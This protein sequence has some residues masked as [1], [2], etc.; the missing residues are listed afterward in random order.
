M[1]G[2]DSINM[3]EN[4]SSKLDEA[5]EQS[6]YAPDSKKNTRHTR[7]TRQETIVLIQAKLAVENR[8]RARSIPFSIF[9]SDQNEPKWDSVSSYCK[10]HGVGREP[11]Q[12]QKRWSNLLGDFK[13]IKTWESHIKEGAESFWTMRSN[14]RRERKLPGLFD[15]EV[16]DILD[17]REFPMAATPLA[18]VTA[19]TE[20]DSSSVDQVAMAAATA[21]EEQKNE[22]EEADEEI[23]LENDKE[24]IAM[25]SPAKTDGNLS[26]IS[27][28]AKEKDPG[29]TAGTGSMIQKGLKR[30]RLSIDGSEDINWA[31]VLERS[32]NMLSSQLESQN[33][34]YQLDRDQRKEQADSLV[35]ALNKL[36]DVLLRI[37]NKL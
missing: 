7:W 30:R 29:S 3:Q 8:A 6:F 23:G 17:G 27:G 16:Y 36:T 34:N 15:R 18:H 10:Q 24:T 2:L 35:A 37:V 21:E 11:V 22:D 19:M 31:K 32:S 12:C 26:P 25:R 4:A 14:S 1:T 5:K 20:I 13:K 9:S 28:E 33:I